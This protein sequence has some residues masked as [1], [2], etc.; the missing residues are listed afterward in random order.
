MICSPCKDCSKKNL[1]KE[2][3]MKGCKMI[4]AVQQMDL[5]LE[6]FNEGCGID[7]S[8]E[9]EYNVEVSL[10]SSFFATFQ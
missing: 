9:Y 6:K 3:C 8:E 7:Y 10:N 5:S 1:P 4:V 2:K